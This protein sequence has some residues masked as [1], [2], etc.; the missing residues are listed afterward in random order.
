M[1]LTPVIPE[2]ITVHLGR[3]DE[4]ADNV[5]IPFRSYIK[6]VAS[7]EV[8][9]TWNENALRANIYA[10]IS[11]ALN[12]VY[13]E[14]YRS[15][16][17]NFDITNSIA[18]DQSFFYGRDIYENISSIVDEIFNSYIRR[19][20]FVEPLFATY[21][22]GIEVTCPGLSQWGSQ[23]LAERGYTPYEIL[24][25]Y[26]GEDI[27]IVTDVPVT[28]VTGSV[29][30]APLSRNDSGNEVQLIQIR[31]NRISRNFPGIPKIYPTDGIFGSETENAVRTFQSTFG[32]TPDGIVGPATWYEIQS[33]YNSVKR[34]SEITSE[35]LTFEEISTQFPRE[36]S[37][38]M[39]GS[40]V[41]VL[42][43]FLAYVGSFLDSI[44]IITVDGVYGPATVNAVNAFQR[45]YGL[46]ETGVVDL[47]TWDTLYNV[48]LGLIETV[49]LYYTEGV[50]IPFP[51]RILRP[52]DEG[53]DVRVLQEYLNYIGT[54]YAEIPSINVDG[55]YGNQTADAIFAFAS[56]FGIPTETAYVNSILWDAIASVYDD[57]YN[58][59]IAPDR[60]YPGY[61]LERSNA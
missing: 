32:L 21:C 48:Y 45:T 27:D 58:G 1:P 50:V 49:S 20:G 33:I 36:L 7:S 42:Q 35:G 9:P 10:Q 44:P 28:G 5:T 24:Q 3:P 12:R 18:N 39:S 8:F 41:R 34:L 19:R 55:I 2:Y 4:D 11:V 25:Y 52:G 56:L 53:D 23:D 14:F 13:T 6:N 61:P 47:L 22:D 60:Q 31:L 59:N 17:Y 38:G 37:E 16:G 54:T 46:P 43:Y 26:Y 29:P 15:R 57:I 30:A 40:S 51:G